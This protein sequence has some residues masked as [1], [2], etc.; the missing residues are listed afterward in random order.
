QTS[1]TDTGLVNGT[2]YFYTVA[3]VNAAGTSPPSNE[4]SATP[5]SA[6]M[7]PSAPT[8]LVG[9]PGNGSVALSWTA[10]ASNGGAAVT[11]Y[12]VYRGTSAGG[13]SA[14][15][16]ASSVS[17]TSFTDTGLVN[18]TAYFYTVAAVNAAG[19][20]PPSN[21]ASATPQSAVMVPSAPT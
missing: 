3:A 9:T 14:T 12:N 6:V 10:P 11:G 1:F 19:T 5:Q 18:G 2:A 17:G 20:S 7:V 16:I 15:A 8:G 21:E 13:E 4:A